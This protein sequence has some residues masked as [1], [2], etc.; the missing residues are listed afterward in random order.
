MVKEIKERA[1]SYREEGKRY[2]LQIEE[3]SLMTSEVRAV[4]EELK[5]KIARTVAA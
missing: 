4:C 5:N 3:C 2:F 1:A